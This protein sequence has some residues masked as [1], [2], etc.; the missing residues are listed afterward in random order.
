MSSMRPEERIQ[1]PLAP[2][3]DTLRTSYNSLLASYSVVHRA[4][5]E[6]TEEA[7]S[8]RT[9][10]SK[11]DEWSGA[12][13]LQAIHDLNSEIVQLSA[14]VADEFSSSL[15]RSRDLTRTS[16]RELV[17]NAL[18]P[19]MMNLLA[20]RDH[21]ADPTLVQFAI[22]AWEVSCVGKVL[23][24]FCY[25]LPADVDQF[26][27]GVF[28]H[29]HRAEPQPTSSRWRALTYTHARALLPTPAGG[30]Q[31]DPLRNLLDTNIRGL[32]AILALS[33]CT[34]SR[35]THREP[36][37]ARFGAAL[38]RIGQSAER[39]AS[40]MKEGVMST[41]FQ[42]TWIPPRGTKRKEK[43]K[44]P[45]RWFDWATMEN[46][47]A[48][49]ASE[50]SRVLCTVELGL[51]CTRRTGPTAGD[52]DSTSQENGSLNGSVNGY[53]TNG[54]TGLNYERMSEPV[55]TRNLLLK[56]KVLLESV[57]DIL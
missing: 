44:E 23:D 6:R 53:G 35:G 14:S 48:G 10:L 2:E 45:E 15:D 12:Q 28:E 34:D 8:L 29:M 39:I 3:T 7:G 25:G 55:L 42:V 1:F 50:R 32:L 5:Q 4:L 43:E 22:Q 49:H 11:T 36:L 56:P 31:A 13:L 54:S 21:M 33:G 57:T 51:T 41:V 30:G 37:R 18:G 16:D 47:Y 27:N 9:F 40:A 20:S 26:L 52:S 17:N 19:V 46:I 38:V 24:A